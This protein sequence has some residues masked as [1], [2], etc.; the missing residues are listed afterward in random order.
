MTENQTAAA[1]TLADQLTA[2]AQPI[3]QAGQSLVTLG[4]SLATLVGSGGGAVVSLAGGTDSGTSLPTSDTGTN[5]FETLLPDLLTSLF[6]SLGGGLTSLFGGGED[7]SASPGVG[8]LAAGASGGATAGA[9]GG[10]DLDEGEKKR[11]QTE[12][13]EGQKRVES[14]KKVW[15]SKLA[16]AVAGSKKLAAVHKAMAIAAV[17]IDTAKGISSAFSGPPNG[18]PWPLNIAQAALVAATGAKQI[19]AIKGQ[20]HDGLDKVPS[21]GT[22]LLEKGERVVDKRL[23]RDLS[24]YLKSPQTTVNSRENTV[25]NSPSVNLTINGNAPADSVE[26]NRGALE[27]MIRDIFADHALAAPFD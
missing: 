6:E 20:A 18:P 10:G 24:S 4:Q 13:E 22:Y 2:L 16:N 15:A 23:N 17:V 5:P 27:S 9:L 14:D 19:S 21:T 3:G 26:K 12:Q 7:P 8:G 25:T 11:T 1:P